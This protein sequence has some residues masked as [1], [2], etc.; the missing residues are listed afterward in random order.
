MRT[1]AAD[2]RYTV[3]SLGRAPTLV[4]TVVVTLAL[5]LGANGAVFALVDRLFLRP[6]P[7]VEAPERVHRLYVTQPQRSGGTFTRAPLNYL[8]VRAVTAALAGSARVAAYAHSERRLGQGPDAQPVKVVYAGP[9]YFP[10]LGVRVTFGRAFVPDEERIDAAAPVAVLSD[11]LWRRAF[12]A[13]PAVVGRT[14][15]SSPR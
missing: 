13:D 14:N 1:A 15:V 10:T 6:P 7:G 3:R 5:G 8:E 9:G 12:G 11:A 2:V 4:A